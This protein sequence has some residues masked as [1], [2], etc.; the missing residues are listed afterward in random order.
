MPAFS[1]LL[2]SQTNKSYQ[3]S[4]R[5]N[6]LDLNLWQGR[7]HHSSY[8]FLIVSSYSWGRSHPATALTFLSWRWNSVLGP[9]Q[10]TLSD[11]KNVNL[12]I[13]SLLESFRKW[14]EFFHSCIDHIHIQTG[15]LPGPEFINCP[16]RGYK[17]S[18][19]IIF[20]GTFIL[21]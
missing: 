17:D 8:K 20:S 7:S 3:E 19:N 18:L 16:K 12:S 14:I 9:C 10:L 11:R 15:G 2:P 4:N 13:N 5:T 21:Y 1:S 6:H